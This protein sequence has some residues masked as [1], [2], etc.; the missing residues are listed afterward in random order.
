MDIL[1]RDGRIVA[2]QPAGS[3]ASPEEALV[4]DGADKT[5]I[6]GIINLQGLAGWVRSPES[7]A[8]AFSRPEILRQLGVYASYGVTTTTTV[9]P[10]GSALHEIRAEIESGRIPSAARIL[11]PL[12]SLT[13][14]LPRDHREPPLAAIAHVVESADDARKAVERLAEEGADYIVFEHHDDEWSV[15]S[16]GVAAAIVKHTLGKGLE[17]VVATSHARAALDLVE[18]GSRLLVGSIT[19]TEV[20]GAFVDALRSAGVTYVPALNAQA[21]RFEFGERAAWLDDRYLRRSLPSGVTGILKGPM[22]TRQALD[23]DR[24]LKAHRFDTARRNLRR[25]AGAGV[26]IGFASGSGVRGSFE[27]YS[28]YRE[29][30][31]LQRSGLSTMEIIRA[32]SLG[33]AAGLGIEESRGVLRPGADADLVVLNANPLESIHALRE[34]H[35]VLIL[36][37]LVRL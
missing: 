11:T 1:I 23:P 24:A 21:V 36:G 9:G 2:L 37:C 15:A 5:V 10:Q 35:A 13:T 28:E 6:P 20:S 19:N 17:P 31:Q 7:A 4:I 8:D 14:A 3:V 33:S 25:I 18:A 22:R 12:R 26:R 16:S 34:L 29:A 32:F 30:V 27:G